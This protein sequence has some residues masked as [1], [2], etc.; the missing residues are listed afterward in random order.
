M[1]LPH[2]LSQQL[3]LLCAYHLLLRLESIFAAVL[4]SPA[5]LVVFF[6]SWLSACDTGR[7]VVAM[8]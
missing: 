4:G 2:L 7:N 1:L 5:V 3:S 8:T 6:A